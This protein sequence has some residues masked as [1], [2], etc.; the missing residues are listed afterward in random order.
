MKITELLTHTRG[1]MKG[2]T[3]FLA[4]LDVA[5]RLK[6]GDEARAE[7]S[8]ANS[9]ASAES[10]HMLE[11]AAKIFNAADRSERF[12]A[13]SSFLDRT[14]DETIGEF[15]IRKDAC[16]QV[17]NLVGE[18][19]SARFS[20]GNALRP[21][22][23]Y[24]YRSDIAGARPHISFSSVNHEQCHLL[25]NMLEVLDVSFPVSIEKAWPW[26]RN[27]KPASQV[28]I[29]FPPFGANLTNIDGVPNNTLSGLGVSETKSARLSMESLAI[30]DILE[31]TTGKVIVLVSDGALFRMVGTE[32]VARRNLLDS[33]RL[34][35]VMSVPSGLMFTHTAIKTNVL[36]LSE[37]N[38]LE[39]NVRFVDLGH[40]T[41]AH[42][43]HR[44][45][46]DVGPDVNWDTTLTSQPP[47]DRSLLRDIN[48]EEI[49]NNNIVLLPDRYLNIGAKERLDLLL[50]NSDVA[51][52]EELVEMIRPTSLTQDDEG[53]FTLFE[54]SP[55]DLNERG[56][57]RQPARAISV[58]RA[59]Y[60]K[61]FNQQLR[62]GD[63]LLSIKGNV[64]VA[65]M[66]PHEIP[67]EGEAA[68]W[69]A[70]QSMMILRPKKRVDMSSLALFEYFSN[71]TVQEYLRSL[72]GGVAIQ[73]LAMKDLKS[74]PI[75]V[76]DQETV[77]TIEV[78][79]EKRQA[80]IDQIQELRAKLED[81]RDQTWPHKD[82]KPDSQLPT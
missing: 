15:W 75:A 59:K 44:N 11:A 12:D 43:G 78:G 66:I 6:T 5:A 49:R 38:T 23:V 64:G 14:S 34:Q 82:L 8:L 60:N 50:A 79:F 74:F 39:R 32:P 56:F 42:K 73:N 55:S 19:K 62:P 80:I 35:A 18:A 10:L 37:V 17:L 68:I 54:A 53:E 3:A 46:F 1:E 9:T 77:R 61:A 76:P 65:A 51:D 67:K 20:F 70:G 58:E 48:L 25:Q 81:V 40:E 13:I 57:I 71:S 7:A 29:A 26:Q 28:E 36:V 30:S 31:H 24:A 69:T 63:V 22:L 27:E 52:L 72:A 2:M 21:C 47:E 16:D 4:F 33:C 41:V 45:R